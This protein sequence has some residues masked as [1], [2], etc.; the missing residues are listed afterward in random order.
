MKEDNYYRQQ[1]RGLILI[2]ESNAKIDPAVSRGYV[3]EKLNMI[4]SGGIG[5]HPNIARR[6]GIKND[7]TDN[8]EM[9]GVE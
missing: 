4:L 7:E 2:L 5:V 1:I 3:K 8:S 6:V 9:E